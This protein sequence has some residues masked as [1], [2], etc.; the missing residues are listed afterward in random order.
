MTGD[1]IK[2]VHNGLYKN[3]L[4]HPTFLYESIVTMILYFILRKVRTKKKFDGC[5]LC[6]YMLVYGV[7]RFF[8]EGLRTDSLMLVNFR[9]SK[10]LSIVLVILSMFVI[11]RK[12]KEMKEC[13][14]CEEA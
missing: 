8:I 11:I 14:D 2:S 13:G 9:I 5:V 3:D 6:V 12:R 1:I 7:A 4:V 10:V